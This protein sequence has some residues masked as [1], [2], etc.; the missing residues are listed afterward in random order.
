[1]EDSFISAKSPITN[2]KINT[3][4]KEKT[5]LMNKDANNNNQNESKNENEN[6]EILKI[7]VKKEILNS[8]FT[9]EDACDLIR[10]VFIAAG[11]REISVGD[12]VDIW[13]VR[14][15]DNVDDN[16][17]DKNDNDNKIDNNNNDNINKINDDNINDNN[18]ISG[19]NNNDNNIGKGIDNNIIQISNNPLHRSGYFHVEKRFI[20]LAKS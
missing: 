9:V 11:E 5:N 2:N 3:I 18:D 19:N 12:G 4:K 7:Y 13:I 1:M 10:N 14:K 16:N 6:N 15:N 17:S 8:C 20:N